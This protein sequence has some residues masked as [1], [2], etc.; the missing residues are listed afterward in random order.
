L[1]T[2]NS[3]SPGFYKQW[4]LFSKLKIG[5]EKG[6]ARAAMH[7]ADEEHL[8]NQ[9]KELTEQAKPVSQKYY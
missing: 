2:I 1:A 8:R 3:N 7:E 9:I 5:A 6:A 4:T